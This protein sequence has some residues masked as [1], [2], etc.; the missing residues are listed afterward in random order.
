MPGLFG[1]LPGYAGIDA[2]LK[3][4]D[5]GT[6]HATFLALMNARKDS[7]AVKRWGKENLANAEHQAFIRGLMIDK[8][9]MAPSMALAI[10]GYDA[11]KRMGLLT[12]DTTSAPSLRQIGAGYRGM[13]QGLFR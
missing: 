7:G 10:P 11:V 8:P 13:Y 5:M 3:E 1:D 6:P 4:Y 12:D 2:I 9:W